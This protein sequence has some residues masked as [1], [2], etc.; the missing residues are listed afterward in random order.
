M[1]VVIFFLLPVSDSFKSLT[2][3]LVLFN[4]IV[5]RIWFV[6][7][8]IYLKNLHFRNV[9]GVPVVESSPENQIKTKKQANLPRVKTLGY[10]RIEPST[11]IG[12]MKE[13]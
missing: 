6:Y 9:I 4:Y 13:T 5:G 10:H 2:I 12:S 3:V 1:I 11:P 8:I 7:Y